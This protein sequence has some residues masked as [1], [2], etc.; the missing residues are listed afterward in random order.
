MRI[1]LRRL[2]RSLYAQVSCTRVASL[3]RSISASGSLAVRIATTN[4]SSHRDRGHL[5]VVMRGAAPRSSS[6]TALT[7]VA[8]WGRS[9][10]RGSL[11]S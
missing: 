2:R 5:R 7:P 8:H 11:R 10:P 1:S 9:R 6:A 4:V 3:R